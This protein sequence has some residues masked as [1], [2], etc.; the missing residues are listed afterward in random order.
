MLMRQRHNWRVVCLQKGVVEIVIV[1]VVE[2]GVK[3][4]LY[5]SRRTIEFRSFVVDLY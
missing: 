5:I 2:I 1:R 3:I 4:G